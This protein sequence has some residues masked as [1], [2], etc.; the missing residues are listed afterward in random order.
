M[1]AMITTH[2]LANWSYYRQAVRQ[3]QTC[4]NSLLD[5]KVFG[6]NWRCV[7]VLANQLFPSGED[8]DLRYLE[9]RKGKARIGLATYGCI[10]EL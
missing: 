5:G 4:F 8:C 10:G 7:L 3:A 9:Q 2:R 1:C 6:I